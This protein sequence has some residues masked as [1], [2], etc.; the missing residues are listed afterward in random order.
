MI[1]VGIM[2]QSY[3]GC[4][5]SVQAGRCIMRIGSRLSLLALVAAI[6]LPSPVQA[7]RDYLTTEQ[8]AQLEKIQTVL[9]EAIA[10]TDK[11]TIEAAPV[12]DVAA[13]RLA[14][15]GYTVVRDASKPHD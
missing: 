3:C 11:G 8:K 12:A 4:H 5:A 1:P 14:E 7:Y 6:V 2:S 10:L 13:R 15:M 9:V